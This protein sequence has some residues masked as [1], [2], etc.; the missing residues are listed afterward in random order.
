M[1]DDGRKR[2]IQQACVDWVKAEIPEIEIGYPHSITTST[3]D[4]PDVAA[5]VGREEVVASDPEFF[6]FAGLQEVWLHEYFTVVEILIEQK[7]PDDDAEA[8]KAASQADKT[9]SQMSTTL[10]GSSL[11][12]PTLGGRVQMTSPRI[13]V[14]HS[15]PF[16]ERSDGTRGRPLRLE[17]A[18][19]DT[20][21]DPS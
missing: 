17:L 19:A 11:E 4:L 15:Q 5:V 10:V 16:I 8:D 6:P 20:I 7:V 9:V 1:S 2:E 13:S 21:K 14:D 3:G 18:I 12:D